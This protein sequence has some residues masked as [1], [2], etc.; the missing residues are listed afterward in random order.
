[1]FFLLSG[2]SG[3]KLKILTSFKLLFESLFKLVQPVLS[4][5]KTFQQKTD[6]PGPMFLNFSFVT[7]A[8]DK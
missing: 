6:I 4:N 1:L 5:L 3:D 2:H 8:P 7:D